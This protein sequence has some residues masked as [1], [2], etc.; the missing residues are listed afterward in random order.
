MNV[1]ADAEN[2]CAFTNTCE[3]TAQEEN[4]EKRFQKEWWRKN[5]RN[6]KKGEINKWSDET[7]TGECRLK[8]HLR[9]RNTKWR[10]RKIKKKKQERNEWH[11]NEMS[12]ERK[13]DVERKKQRKIIDEANEIVFSLENNRRKK[14]TDETERRRSRA[15]DWKC[16]GPTEAV[17]SSSSSSAL[18]K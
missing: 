18:A 10:R 12:I 2:I 13:R 14:Q 11:T 9:R 7:L 4:K 8:M 16:N 3:N 17:F 5:K 1:T 15:K 6:R